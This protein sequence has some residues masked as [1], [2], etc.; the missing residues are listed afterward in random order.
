VDSAKNTDTPERRFLFKLAPHLGM[1]V[2][3]LERELPYRE[4]VE[5]MQEYRR[6]PWGTW[7]DNTHA[8][9]I[10]TLIGNAF[11]GKDGRPFSVEDFMLLDPE[12]AEQRRAEKRAQYSKSL[13]NALNAI[14]KVH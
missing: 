9:M 4:L 7:R 2:S 5:W 12:T 14:A 13:V 6:D 10:C 1:T 8:G 11:R 3:R